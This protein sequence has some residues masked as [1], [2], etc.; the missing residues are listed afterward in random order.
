MSKYVYNPPY[1]QKYGIKHIPDPK[2]NSSNLNLDVQH[3]L[4]ITS[5]EVLPLEL[6]VYN[7]YVLTEIYLY[8]EETYNSWIDQNGTVE[9]GT[10]VY[11]SANEQ[12]GVLNT[13]DRYR[14]LNQI[15]FNIPEELF[16]SSLP[17]IKINNISAYSPSNPDNGVLWG[18]TYNPD[19]ADVIAP[20][21]KACPIPLDRHIPIYQHSSAV[22][23]Q[24]AKV[25][26]DFPD[27]SS[28]NAQIILSAAQYIEKAL[29][30]V[31]TV[32]GVS[33]S[34]AVDLAEICSYCASSNS[35]STPITPLQ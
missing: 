3:T 33:A 17:F 34:A 32:N 9:T 6:H 19:L 28:N 35:P 13:A 16:N 8:S 27:D 30:S 11:S 7:Q 14:T 4:Q 29:V 24:T 23:Y 1:N 2:N 31:V 5:N 26:I 12:G 25:L 15:T 10:L 21:Y 20:Y 18:H 22:L